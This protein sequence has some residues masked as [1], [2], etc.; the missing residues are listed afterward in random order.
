MINSPFIQKA[1]DQIDGKGSDILSLKITLAMAIEK[2]ETV[3]AQADAQFRAGD[4]HATFN[5]QT[6]D[7]IR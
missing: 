7:S 6:I 1:I 5:K 2:L 4:K 3:I